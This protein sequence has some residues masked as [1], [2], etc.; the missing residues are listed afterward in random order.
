ME[1]RRSRS[2]SATPHARLH[3][4]DC[5]RSSAEDR[6]EGAR[7]IATGAGGAEPS[8]ACARER[9][10]EERCSPRAGGASVEKSVQEYRD[11]SEEMKKK[12]QRKKYKLQFRVFCFFSSLEEAQE[13]EAARARSE[14]PA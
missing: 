4:R 9:E 6:A 5:A 11:R 2:R 12:C 14:A 3:E 10:R 8:L 1:P 7:R 13:E